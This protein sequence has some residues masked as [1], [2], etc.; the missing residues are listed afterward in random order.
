MKLIQKVAMDICNALGT[1]PEGYL[2]NV[3]ADDSG[4]VIGNEVLGFGLS[5]ED[6]G[7]GIAVEKA[8]AAFPA[9]VK[10]V[11]QYHA[12]RSAQS[13]VETFLKVAD[14]IRNE[15]TEWI[16]SLSFQ[17]TSVN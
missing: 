1:L 3:A 10:A 12:I 11:A 17:A 7:D 2:V 4:I 8:K 16:G 9:L 15:G 5:E 13:D 6:I 14:K